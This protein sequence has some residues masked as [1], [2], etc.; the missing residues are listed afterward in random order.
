MKTRKL[1]KKVMLI[2]LIGKSATSLQVS[3]F[4][5]KEFGFQRFEFRTR[6]GQIV[7]FAFDIDTATFENEFDEVLPHVSKSPNQLMYE[8]DWAIRN[9]NPKVFANDLQPVNHNIVVQD[10]HFV[11]DVQRIHEL[12]GCIVRLREKG[13][14]VYEQVS[15]QLLSDYVLEMNLSSQ[16]M[17]I[18]LGRILL[19]IQQRKS[20]TTIA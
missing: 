1:L 20:K 5:E 10:V 8:L 14:N 13:S 3:K 4:L 6:L 11:A 2:G 7:K 19:L 9:I 12:G 18:G 15:P 17:E 16:D